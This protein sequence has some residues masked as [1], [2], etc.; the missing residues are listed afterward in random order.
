MLQ[1]Y[2][3]AFQCIPLSLQYRPPRITRKP[4]M[5]GAQTALVVGT[6]GKEI[7]PDKYGRVKVQ[8]L[9][10]RDGKYNASSSCW[11]RV[12]TPWAGK[13]WGMIHIPRIGHEVVVDFLDGDPD[14]PI[15]IGSVF[16]SEN[17]PP[18]KLPDNATQSGIKTR[19]SLKGT[20]TNFNELAIQKT[21][22]LR[23][24][25]IFMQSVISSGLSRIT[26]RS[27]SAAT[28][29]KP[30]PTGARPTPSTRTGRPRSR[31]ATKNS[32]LRRETEPS[33]SV[34]GTSGSKCPPAHAT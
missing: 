5:E 2:T 9:W 7:E 32:P 12:A 22:K 24:R 10:D 3:N 31:Q 21:K 1:P 25:S 19:S 11:V 33:R 8:F 14:Q 16:N 29:S 34:R 15:I 20:D 27:P 4:R 30:V 26:T 17:E 23:N 13:N 18:Y 28:T 6:D